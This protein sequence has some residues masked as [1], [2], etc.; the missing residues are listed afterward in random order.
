MIDFATLERPRSP[1][2]YLVCDAQTCRQA[3]ADEEPALFDAPPDAVKAAWDRV[4]AAQL[5]TRETASDPAAGQ[6][7]YVQHSRF[8]RF[9]DTITVRFAA[10]SEA[11]PETGEEAGQGEAHS[12][13][14]RTRLMLYSRSKYGYSDMGVNRRR[15]AAWIAAL[16][17]ELSLARDRP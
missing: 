3:V 8:M 13:S 14:A 4:I 6:Y 7:E 15:A 11:G 9:P 16:R 10:G 12:S 5:R 1:N 2:T 17:A